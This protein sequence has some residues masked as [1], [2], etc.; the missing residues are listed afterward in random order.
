VFDIPSVLLKRDA[1]EVI[2]RWDGEPP[3]SRELQQRLS[4]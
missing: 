4:A 1:D 3:P 2:A